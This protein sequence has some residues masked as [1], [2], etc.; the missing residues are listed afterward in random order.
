SPRV[1]LLARAARR[2]RGHEIDAP[3]VHL[4]EDVGTEGTARGVE[5][6]GI[7]PQPEEHL[8]HDF[9]REGSITEDAVGQPERGPGL[10]LVRLFE[11]LGPEPPDRDH[12]RGVARLAQVVGSH[13][14]PVRRAPSWRMAPLN[15]RG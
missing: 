10:A 15:P 13:H 12:Q 6:L 9:L 8:L 11:R 7:V 5:T 14:T 3:A 1:A 4:R 2:L